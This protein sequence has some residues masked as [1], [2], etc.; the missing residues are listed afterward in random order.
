[1]KKRCIYCYKEFDDNQGEICPFCYK[2]NNQSKM[3]ENE[4]HALHQNC[5]NNIRM[6][7]NMMNN[8][9]TNLVV[10]T[11][12]LIV[13]LI[14]LVLSFRFNVIKERVFTPGSTE[15]VVCVICLSLAGI[16]LI[17]GVFRLIISIIRTRYYKSVLKHSELKK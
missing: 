10:G 13:G 3:S 7:T 6:S 17:L 14:F 11:I 15:F 12:L 5:H 16:M 2:D 9:L 4:V 8:A 1:M